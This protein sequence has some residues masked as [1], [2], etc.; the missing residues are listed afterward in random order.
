MSHENEHRAHPVR[1]FFYV[2]Y[3]IINLAAFVGF[4]Y[5]LASVSLPLRSVVLIVTGAVLALGVSVGVVRPLCRRK[6]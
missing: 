4:F 6:K 1:N 3:S 2:I 5:A